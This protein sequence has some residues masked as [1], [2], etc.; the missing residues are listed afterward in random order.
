MLNTVSAVNM[1]SRLVIMKTNDNVTETICSINKGRNI[2][3]IHCT[4]KVL[5]HLPYPIA[6]L[7]ECY[8]FQFPQN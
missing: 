2:S 1:L 5:A 3:V 4:N 8:H 7:A 6:K